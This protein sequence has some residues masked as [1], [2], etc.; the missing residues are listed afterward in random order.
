MD[1]IRKYRAIAAIISILLTIFKFGLY[2]CKV[3]LYGDI[4]ERF[5]QIGTISLLY[6]GVTFLLFFVNILF[7]WKFKIIGSKTKNWFLIVVAFMFICYSFLEFGF[8]LVSFT[9]YHNVLNENF[10]MITYGLI[11]GMLGI[12]SFKLRGEFGSVEI[13]AVILNLVVGVFVL[14]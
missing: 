7:F 9:P 2:T 10:M 1:K 12:S 11:F 4:F 6:F 13:A 14:N 5:I 8:N 3:F